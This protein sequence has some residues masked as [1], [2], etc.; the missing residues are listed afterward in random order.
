MHRHE[1]LLEEPTLV[2]CLPLAEHTVG[3]QT[4]QIV[5]LNAFK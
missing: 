3:T 1:V 4:K 5:T 2:T